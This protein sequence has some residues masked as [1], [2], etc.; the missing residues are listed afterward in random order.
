[1]NPMIDTPAQSTLVSHPDELFDA[2]TNN[3]FRPQNREVINNY[4]KF[5]KTL[6]KWSQL[7]SI[8]HT[9]E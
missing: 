8:P 7:L 1:M 3:D 2:I 5:D 4:W 6:P 9:N